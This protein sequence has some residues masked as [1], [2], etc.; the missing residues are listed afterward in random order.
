MRDGCLTVAGM[1]PKL[2]VTLSLIFYFPPQGKLCHLS[3]IQLCALTVWIVV[4]SG[5]RH[6]SR[7]CS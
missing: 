7:V 6:N 3:V 5:K 1:I 2:Q 4:N